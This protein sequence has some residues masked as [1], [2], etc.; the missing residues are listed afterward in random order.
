MSRPYMD[1]IL[2]KNARELLPL[3]EKEAL[4][5][6]GD[7]DMM[8]LLAMGY[9]NSDGNVPKD[10]ARAIYW[11]QRLGEQGNSVAEFNLGLFYAQGFQVPRDYEKA[12]SWMERAAAQGEADAEILSRKYALLAKSLPLAH[13]GDPGAQ[14][15]T[16][17]TLMELS[18]T[19]EP[20]QQKKQLQEAFLWAEQSA[21]KQD[22]VGLWTLALCYEHGRGTE[23]NQ[24]KAAELYKA[25][26]GQEDP[27]CLH[28]LG[29]YY[30]RGDVL[31]LDPEKGYGL[32]LRA[33]QLG[34]GLAMRTVG[35][36]CQSGI[37]REEDMGEAIFWYE[38]AQEID[39]DPELEKSLGQYRI[40]SD[41]EQ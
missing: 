23:E 10:P 30:L 26:A 20:E 5:Q 4:A 13:A 34:Y 41:T 18:G 1:E 2:Q 22:P 7:P 19:L 38:K 9:L 28:S 35:F 12:A 32:C 14:G 17:R 37:G 6:K 33:A 15:E 40:L 29:C 39:Y 21:E 8:E 16:A 24:Q 36:C 11:Y 25:G 31:P 27:A 3:E